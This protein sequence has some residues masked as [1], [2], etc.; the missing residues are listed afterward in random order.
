M[1]KKNLKLLTIIETLGKGGA[2][3]VLVNTLPEL[4]KIGIECEVAILFDTDDL[5]CELN[6]L[7]I[8]V[9]KLKLSYKWNILEA[10]SKLKKLYASNN[11]DIV[12]AHLFFAHFYTAL[13]LL[14]NNNIK[15]VVTF[16]NLGFNEY[17]ANTVFKKVRKKLE[18]FC[19]KQFDRKTAVSRAVMEHYSEHLHL[20]HVD[21]IHNSFPIDKF[22]QYKTKKVEKD[23]FSV[24]M[25][26]RLVP[27][28]GHKFFIEAIRILNT[29]DLK[30]Q[31]F[32]VGSGPLE[33]EIKLQIKDIDNV[34]LKDAIPHHALMELYNDMDLIVVPSIH[35][36]FGLV[37]GEAMIMKKAIVATEVDGIVEMITNEKEG[38]LVPSKDA[39]SLSS[40]I[41]RVYHDSCLKST[42]S[43]N[44]EEKI[45][46]F[47]T[48]IIAKQWKKYYDK[49]QGG[50]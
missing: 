2:E 30:I 17:P 7:G 42:L 6:S 23:T 25:P 13:S 15:K 5:A 43:K 46:Q 45:V 37:V 32:I 9:H 1:M 24:L 8:K 27:K 26:G 36:A 41:E 38:L 44:A 34:T 40:A 11:Y 3:R 49:L 28:K 21:I 16:H 47:D 12:H 20:E 50:N 33:N 29:K 22:Q 48:K 35:E 31:Y 4:Q 14:F 10:T 19:V 39:K 18:E